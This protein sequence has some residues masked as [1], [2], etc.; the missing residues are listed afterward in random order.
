MNNLVNN[1]IL[2]IYVYSHVLGGGT[3]KGPCSS[4]RFYSPAVF[5]FLSVYFFLSFYSFIF[6]GWLGGV[7]GAITSLHLHT[8][9]LLRHI[10]FFLPC[11]KNF[12]SIS[13]SSAR[14]V[15]Y[16]S[17]CHVQRS[18][19]ALPCLLLVT[20]YKLLDATSQELP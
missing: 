7:G 17:C 15:I 8:H 4:C 16:F 13:T 9:L 19:L 6:G 3:C 2:Y 20:L 12:S 5:V 10:L 1:G 18:S 14:Y 11:Q